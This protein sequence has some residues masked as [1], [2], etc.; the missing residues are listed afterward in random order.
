MKCGDKKHP[1]NQPRSGLNYLTV[2][3]EFFSYFQTLTSIK[4]LLSDITFKNYRTQTLKLQDT[5]FKFA[6]FIF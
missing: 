2:Q 3:T 1:K 4:A 6:G 5:N